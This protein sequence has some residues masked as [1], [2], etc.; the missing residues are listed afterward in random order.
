[1][2][3]YTVRIMLAELSAISLLWCAIALATGARPTPMLII[4]A[5]VGAPIGALLFLWRNDE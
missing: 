4:G 3:G 1:M 5:L 2:R